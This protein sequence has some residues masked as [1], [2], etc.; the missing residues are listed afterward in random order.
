MKKH[1]KSNL[2]AKI[3][4]IF[5]VYDKMNKKIEG[6]ISMRIRKKKWAENEIANSNLVINENFNNDWKNYFGNENEIC[7]EL[8]CGKGKFINEM[9]QK[10]PGKN[11]IAV[12]KYFHIIAMGVRRANNS[13][14][15]LVFIIDDISHI[16][17]YFS[18]TKVSCIYINFC[19]PWHKKRHYKRRLTYKDF[20][21]VYK[22]ILIPGASIYFKTDNLPLFEFTL[23]QFSDNSWK[24]K[25]ITFDLHKTNLDN[26]TTEYE[27]KFSNAG[28]PIYYCEAILSN[29]NL[30]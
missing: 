17:K 13:L 7:L 30:N 27:E 1:I 18:K 3:F 14:K 23:N 25:N 11:F 19:D 26:I 16:E 24:L 15:N 8:G 9:A 6:E 2:L 4:Y 12:E 22:K 20:L 21:D 10:F 29:D 5:H 28:M